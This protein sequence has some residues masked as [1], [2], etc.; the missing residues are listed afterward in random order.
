MTQS[1][2]CLRRNNVE[3]RNWQLPCDTKKSADEWKNAKF[4]SN[5]VQLVMMASPAHKCQSSGVKE[6]ALLPLAVKQT[7]EL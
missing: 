7:S 2:G 3:L 4:I 1:H 6:S 5:L